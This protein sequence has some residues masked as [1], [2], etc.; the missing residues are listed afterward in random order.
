MHPQHHSEVA[1]PVAETAVVGIVNNSDIIEANE[2]YMHSVS[3]YNSFIDG[4][5]SHAIVV[6]DADLC[7]KLLHL[8]KRNLRKTLHESHWIST[9][10]Y[11]FEY[12]NEAQDAAFLKVESEL[13][14]QKN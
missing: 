6:G 14:S 4:I 7:D 2:R 12:T 13:K 5:L 10:E 9:D 3:R 8:Y 11:D 1:E